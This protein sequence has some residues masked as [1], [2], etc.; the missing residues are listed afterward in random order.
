PLGRL[1]ATRLQLPLLSTSWSRLLVEANR[2]AH[3]AKVWSRFTADLPESERE[4]ILA[5]Y[6]RPHRQQVEQAIRAAIS[7]HGNVVHV[8]VHSFTPEL[9]GEVRNADV[10]LLYDSKR[11]PEV[12]LARRW[13]ER[14]RVAVPGLRVRNN[15][16]YRGDTD[17]LPTA[18]RKQHGPKH[19]RGYEL[20]VNQALLRGKRWRQVGEALA[21]TLADALAKA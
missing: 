13:G 16:P 14:L 3:L 18:L 7:T 6:W 11:R 5:R 20:E 21:A 12:D 10:A 9:D 19:Y 1:M 4:R 17:G 2:S 15:Y 8:A